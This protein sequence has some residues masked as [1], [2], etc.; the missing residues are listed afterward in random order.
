MVLS[1]DVNSTNQVEIEDT[2]N[3]IVKETRKSLPANKRTIKLIEQL[4]RN[5]TKTYF[6]KRSIGRTNLFRKEK[7]KKTIYKD[8]VE[9]LES[10][11]NRFQAFA[12]TSLCNKKEY[13]HIS[14]LKLKNNLTPDI[15][16]GNITKEKVFLNKVPLESRDDAYLLQD[17]P[18]MDLRETGSSKSKSFEIPSESD[19]FKE[20]STS[21]LSKPTVGLNLSNSSVYSPNTCQSTFDKEKVEVS[22]QHT[23]NSSLNENS[24][25]TKSQFF[26]TIDKFYSYFDTKNEYQNDIQNCDANLHQVCDLKNENG[27]VL[28]IKMDTRQSYKTNPDVTSYADNEKVILTRYLEKKC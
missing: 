13:A 22:L 3:F 19:T 27:K 16:E 28:S 9:R 18:V 12:K 21:K 15:N 24:N 26:R 4:S 14:P 2:V 7:T 6:H 11:G 20:Y 17:D 8:C 25:G 23:T 10:Q 5:D 1:Y